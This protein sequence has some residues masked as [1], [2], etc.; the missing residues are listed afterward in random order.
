MN[1]GIATLVVAREKRWGSFPAKITVNALLIGIKF[2]R[3]VRFPFVSFV[4]HGYVKKSNCAVS[5]K[6]EGDS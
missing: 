4:G 2:S 6:K 3:N 5:V 1:E